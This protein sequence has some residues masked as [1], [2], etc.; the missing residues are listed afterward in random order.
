[1]VRHRNNLVRK[2]RKSQQ[3]Y[4]RKSKFKRNKNNNHN[5]KKNKRRLKPFSRR[6][7]FGI[8]PYYLTFSIILIILGIFL[9]RISPNI[10]G[11]SEALFWM[12]F[13]GVILILAG[14][15][16]I[17]AYWRNNVSN[18]NTKHNFNWKN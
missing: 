14:I 3:V 16:M 17:V 5:F 1:M 13:L 4:S 2:K 10:F 9:I 11:F 7:L 12:Q 18:F 15:L 6:K 8:I